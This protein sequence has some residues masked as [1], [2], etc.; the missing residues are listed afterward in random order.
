[1]TRAEWQA[2]SAVFAT[3]A[4]TLLAA[5]LWGLAYYA[6]GYAVE[7]A[8]KAC[9]MERLEGDIGLFFR[10]R[11]FQENAWKHDLTELARV[12]D[13]TAALAAECKVNAAFDSA[14]T[15]ACLWN[16]ASR[17]DRREQAAAEALYAAIIEPNHGVLPWIMKRW[18]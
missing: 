15:E 10:E 16:E 7:C 6:A 1:M 8:L 9:V 13:L 11:R 17:Y 18:N 4:G 2:L 3:E 12:A 5:K 14:W